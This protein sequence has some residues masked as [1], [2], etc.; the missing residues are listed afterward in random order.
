LTY[1][2]TTNAVALEIAG[3]TVWFSVYVPVPPVPVPK[4]L[5]YVPFPKR[6][7]QRGVVAVPIAIIPFITL[8]TVRVLLE[9][10]AR[11]TVPPL[12]MVVLDTVCELFTV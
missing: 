9:V 4:A 1:P 6:E 11:N 5:I 12:H 2:V 3:A 8:V 7:A 10:V